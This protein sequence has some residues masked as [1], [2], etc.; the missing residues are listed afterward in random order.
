[1]PPTRKPSTLCHWCSVNCTV[2]VKIQEEAIFIH[3][4]ILLL[5]GLNDN[6]KAEWHDVGARITTFLLH[7]SG[8]SQGVFI[9][10]GLMSVPMHVYIHV[11]NC[12]L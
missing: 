6:M 2:S 11:L 7:V 1:M 3:V 5:C 8:T 12:V 4:M 9:N 10:H